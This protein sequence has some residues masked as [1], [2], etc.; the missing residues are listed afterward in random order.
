LLTKVV[1]SLTASR[2]F[3]FSY[4]GCIVVIVVGCIAGFLVT[5]RSSFLYVSCT[6]VLG[7]GCTIVIVV[8]CI[9][10]FLVMVRSSF[11]YVSCTIVLGVGCIIVIVVGCIVSSGLLLEMLDRGIVGSLLLYI[12]Y[13]GDFLY[14]GCIIAS[15]ASCTG[16][17]SYVVCIGGFLATVRSLQLYVGCIIA[18]SASCTGGFLAT[19]GSSQL[20]VSCTGD[21]WRVFGIS[22]L[23]VGFSYVGCIREDVI[24]VGCIIDFL[25]IVRISLL[26][27]GCIFAIGMGCIGNFLA[28]VGISLLYIGCT[29]DFSC[30][31]YTGDFLAIVRSSLLRVFGILL[32]AT[33][34]RGVVGSL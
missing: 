29:G 22:L 20:Y 5:V 4:V 32:L 12:G 33:S 3:E 23:Y 15:S 2:A 6:I 28:T 13:I 25:A 8:G 34:G 21:F 26:Y 10:G 17:F 16:D 31:C 27:I 18:L 7:I 9:A 14:V 19:V 11:L 24:G 30:I 1:R